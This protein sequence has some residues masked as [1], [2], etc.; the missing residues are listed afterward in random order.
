MQAFYTSRKRYRYQ[1]I[2]MYIANCRRGTNNI[3]DGSFPFKCPSIPMTVNHQQEYQDPET[4]KWIHSQL[5]LVSQSSQQKVSIA[6][7]EHEER[8]DY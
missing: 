5:S 8:E 4:H 3:N 2:E 6:M 7:C 1:R